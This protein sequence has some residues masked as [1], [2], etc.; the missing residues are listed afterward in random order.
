[1]EDQIAGLLSFANSRFLGS[2]PDDV[3]ADWMLV[4]P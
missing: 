4:I 3:E 2:R 1:M